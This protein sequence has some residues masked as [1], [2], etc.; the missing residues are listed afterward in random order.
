M[1]VIN[2][3]ETI[4][5]QTNNKSEEWDELWA[6]RSQTYRPRSDI[7]LAWQVFI[8]IIKNIHHHSGRVLVYMCVCVRAGRFWM[9][10][11]DLQS[12]ITVFTCRSAAGSSTQRSISAA[13]SRAWNTR[14]IVHAKVKW[15]PHFEN[16][17]E[18]HHVYIWNISTAWS[19]WSVHCGVT[20]FEVASTLVKALTTPTVFYS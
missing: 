3:R 2:F 18:T 4:F 7:D 8:I 15:C 5:D 17:Q 11:W 9:K 1:A 6:T 20:G 13:R 10:R 14:S 16:R 12:I 19:K